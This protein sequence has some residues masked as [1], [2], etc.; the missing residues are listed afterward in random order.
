MARFTDRVSLVTGAGS[1]LGRATAR[2]LADEEAL[3]AVLDLDDAAAAETGVIL[4]VKP[5]DG[6]P[7][8]IVDP[9][10]LHQALSNLVANALR[11]TPAGGRITLSAER[12]AG[13]VELVVADTG[14]GIDA[15]DLPFIFDRFWR[16]DRARG[17]G[18]S[19]L[20]LPI[21]RRLVEAHGG[22]ITVDSVVGE[23]TR[24]EG[25]HGEGTRGEGARFVI[26]LPG[27]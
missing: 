9:D 20:G 27:G 24:G 26:W 25:T 23:R 18:G 22:A 21:A 3:V 16:G 11:H 4:K 1:G 15:A 7:A 12:A 10:R 19:G 8:V 2:R 17:R 13:G 5:V 14:A 6:A